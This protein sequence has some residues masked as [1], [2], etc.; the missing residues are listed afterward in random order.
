A[1][2]T[3][4]LGG[5]AT[6][7]MVLAWCG[8]YPQRPGSRP[9][10]VVGGVGALALEELRQLG[11]DVEPYYSASG[12]WNIRLNQEATKIAL[13]RV[14][15]ASGAEVS[16]HTAVAG[17]DVADGRI[18]ALRLHDPRGLREARA[19]AFVDATGDAVL[20]FLAGAAP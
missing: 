13:D 9:D 19:G 17:A 8:F 18:A 11:V 16:L 12:N 10:P 5:A 14:A 15:A 6:L 2:A 20:A 1:E 4:F 3:G 7:S